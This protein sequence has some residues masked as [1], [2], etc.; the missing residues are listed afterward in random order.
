MKKTNFILP[1]NFDNLPL[2]GTMYEPN[3]Q[4]EPKAIL[5]L[6]HGMCE[7]KGRYD[8]MISYF[9]ERGYVAVMHDHRGHGETA[10]KE[11]DNGYFG[12]KTAK[13]IVQD[14][15]IEMIY[16]DEDK[17]NM[18]GKIYYEPNF[19]PDINIDLLRS[20]NYICH[21]CVVKKEL[22]DR[23]G[24]LR[25]EFDGAQDYDFI[26]RCTTKAKRTAHVPR[27]LYHWRCPC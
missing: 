19:K 20:M 27:I 11:E 24:L 21:L 1:S 12:D 16:S 6:C 13:A 7:H 8:E 2:H 4:I 23:A 26:L 3:E 15:D 10:E 5:Q 9:V 18:A 22:I 17:V 14:A 25:S